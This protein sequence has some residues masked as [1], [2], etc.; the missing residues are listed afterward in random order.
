MRKFFR[1][2]GKQRLLFLAAVSIHIVFC[3]ESVVI[4]VVSGELVNVITADYTA[5]KQAGWD[6]G[7][8]RWNV[9][10]FF[11]VCV[12]QLVLSVVNDFVQKKFVREVK[13][14]MR[15]CAGSTFSRKINLKRDEIAAFTSFLNNEIPCI[16]DQYFLGVIDIAGCTGILLC[17]CMALFQLHS[18]LAAIIIVISV[19]IVCI[20]K[21]MKEKAGSV[22]KVYTSVLAAYNTQVESC[23]KGSH[24]LRAYQYHRRANQ[25]LEQKNRQVKQAEGRMAIC[26]VEVQGL[27]AVLQISKTFLIFVVGLW[28]I[29]KGQM[30]VGGLLVA[31]QLAGNVAAP[32]EVLAYTFHARNEAKPLVGKYEQMVVVEETGQKTQTPMPQNFHELCVENLSYGRNGVPILE[33]VSFRFEAGKKYMISGKSGSGK[34]TLLRII[35]QMQE[36]TYSGRITVDGMDIR[37]IQKESYY[38]TVGIVFQEPYLFWASLEENILLGREIP[39]ERFQKILEKLNLSGLLERFRGQELNLETID[40]L[41]GGEKQ[42]IALARAMVGSPKIYLLD[43]ATSALDEENSYRVEEMLLSE[44]ALVLHVCHKP[45]EKLRSAYDREI[46]FDKKIE[47]TLLT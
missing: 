28:L 10:L 9:T 32:I 45:T 16:A 31:V 17:T 15:G 19:L 46:I 35:G 11:I 2:L 33:Q 30:A 27:T 43:E 4:P 34:S 42:R 25:W 13:A 7:G 1:L 18:I 5:Q 22:R 39:E 41:S 29:Q 24:I 14:E 20:P 37:Q 6:S 44:K 21:M 36:G 8:I 38:Q 40:T 26:Q 23:L 3:I 47:K 12:I